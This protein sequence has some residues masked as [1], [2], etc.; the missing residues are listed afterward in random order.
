MLAALN[1]KE[2]H[3]KQL[4]QKYDVVPNYKIGI[5]V[6]I[7]IFGKRSTWDAKYFPNFRVAHLVGS[8]QLEVSDP[9]GK[10]RRVNICDTH[11]I[12]PLDHIVGSILD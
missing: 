9:K 1:T 3:S 5:L 8:R 12:L 10:T 4:K 7:K 11:K 2:A 6:M